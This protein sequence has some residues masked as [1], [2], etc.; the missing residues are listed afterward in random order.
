MSDWLIALI[1]SIVEGLTEFLPVSSTG[2]LILVN[3][4]ANFAD[5][6]FSQTFDM[7]IQVGAIGSVLVYFWRK[8]W[9]IDGETKKLKKNTIDIWIKTIIG[10]IPALIL[11][12][13][14]K[15]FIEERLLNSIVVAVSLIIGGI[16]LLFV[17]KQLNKPTIGTIQELSY[18]KAFGIGIV[19]CLAMVPGVSRS[20][21]SI[22][23]GMAFGMNRV[24]A[25]EFSFY[26]AI[27]TLA[28]ASAYF[29]IKHALGFNN[30]QFALLGFG[31]IA[32]FIVAYLVIALFMKYIQKNDFVPFGV[33][34]IVLGCGILLYFY[35]NN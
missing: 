28:A 11:G 25:A 32:S 31:F 17:E 5:E 14:F 1:L 33:Y 34:R 29:M 3:E 18:K 15:D 4:F 2:H 26:L 20:A 21:S 19:Q 8:L 35:M 9:I 23:G 7:F 6:D 27:P 30:H 12:F 13:L 16:I 22:I 24:A 10:V